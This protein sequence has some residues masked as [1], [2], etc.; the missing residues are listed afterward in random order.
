[1]AELDDSWL[2][3]WLNWYWWF[4]EQ[5]LSNLTYHLYDV[6]KGEVQACLD[7]S[8]EISWVNEYYQRR[9]EAIA[10]IPDKVEPD[11]LNQA[12]KYSQD[13]AN[14]IE[15]KFLIAD[16]TV[17]G[18]GFM[19]VTPL[20]VETGDSISVTFAIKNIGNAPS[21]PF[22]NR[23]FLSIPPYIWHT[24]IALGTFYMDSLPAGSSQQCTVE[25]Q[26]PPNVPSRDYYV[27]VYTDA[28]RVV[29]ESENLGLSYPNNIG[30]TSPQ[31][32]SVS[33]PQEIDL[34]AFALDP[35]SSL[36][37]GET[38][39]VSFTVKNL[40]VTPSGSFINRVFL[41]SSRESNEICIGSCSM[42]SLAGGI[43][44]EA[45][46][47]V[48]IPSELPSNQYYLTVFADG[49]RTVAETNE[50]NNICS[51]S[52]RIPIKTTP[53]PTIAYSPSSITFPTAIE[54]GNNPP[55]QFFSIWNS[56]GGRLDWSVDTDVT[57]L[58]LEPING[59]CTDGVSKVTVSADV[60]G[61][62][63]G[64][65]DT[66]IAISAPGVE[67]L[68]VPVNLTI[69]PALYPDLSVSDALVDD[70][71]PFAGD[72][73][74]V[75]AIVRAETLQLVCY[76]LMRHLLVRLLRPLNMAFSLS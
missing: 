32:L 35:P 13:L 23:V 1:M 56:D 4:V 20:S 25:V 33:M 71:S 37:L 62:A 51:I 22:A 24:D 15:G 60:S 40:G 69:D 75:Q 41:S 42:G 34:T 12:A 5:I 36:E 18:G 26:I 9:V 74:Q 58:D 2:N 73:I 48:T 27:T 21:G 10:S 28:F 76:T 11:E 59:S 45:T 61:I 43:S 68:E 16:L 67:T 30:S 39:S 47:D 31:M 17:S 55:S 46:V 8:N 29:E 6:I 64:P 54:G 70:Y 72:Q 44:Q 3:E 63:A 49:W 65:Y 52:N 66:T 7:K 53:S 50:D 14:S 38:T 57:W 19:A